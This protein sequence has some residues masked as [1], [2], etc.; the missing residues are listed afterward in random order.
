M[1]RRPR[2]APTDEWQQLRL[3]AGSPA[4]EAYELL[5]PIVL[6]GQPPAERAQ[7][8]GVPE[9]TLRRKA[10]RFDALGMRSLF[11]ESVPTTGDRRALPPEIR[12]AITDLK[13][14]YRPFGLREIAA[15]CRARFRR[16]VSHHTVR[17]VLA[18]EALPVDPPRRFPPYH[19]IPDP[20]QRRLA[21]VRLARDGWRPT[22]IAGYLETSR[23]TVHAALQRWDEEGWPGLADRPRGPRHP[24]RKVDL[25]AMAAIRR[26]Q[27]NPL[28][29]AFRVHAALEQL[30][31]RLSPRTCGA[32]LAEHRVLGIGRR[33]DR[34]PGEPQAMPFAA[35]RWHQWWSVDA[36]YLEHHGL[37]T[38]KPVYVLAVL[39]NFSRALLASRLSLRQ[40]LTAYLIVLRDALARYGIPEGI[41]SDSGGIFRANRARA[42]YDA[43]GIRKEAIDRGQPWQNYIETMFSVMRRM[44]DHDFAR[45]GSW[46][47]LQ[48]VHARFARDDH[49]RPHQAHRGQPVGRRTPTAV[50]TWIGGRP[51]DPAALDHLFRLRESRVIRGTGR[52][53]FWHRRLDGER[54]LAG[55]RAAVWIDEEAPTIEYASEALARYRVA[56]APDG[57]HRRRVDEPRRFP[58]RF[59]SPQPVLPA[60][61]E[62]AWHPARRSAPYRPR[63]RPTDCG[64]QEPPSSA[65]HGGVAR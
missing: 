65:E 34:V 40:D 64:C 16:P 54:G 47:D 11:A 30:G 50:L 22:A 17:R 36:R 10:A 46:A 60:L 39:D 15:I 12:R 3:L 58:T 27:A 7:E 18:T 4:Q 61:D 6:F 13:A 45:A 25:K 44:A 48:A 57:R 56:F 28:L 5:R 19:A 32:I 2:R 26:L 14:E 24:A 23:Q 62:T 37:G 53:R 33:P 51:C 59:S 43:L 55:E 8:T 21:V 41:V 49:H 42:I 31:I 63:R 1:P 9:R 38:G 52:I 29:G 35:T 20:V